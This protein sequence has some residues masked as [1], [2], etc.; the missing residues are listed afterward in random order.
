MKLD[1][2]MCVVLCTVLIPAFLQDPQCRVVSNLSFCTMINYNVSALYVPDPKKLDDEARIMYN[3]YKDSMKIQ[4]K[5]CMTAF[6]SYTCAFRFPKC[7]YCMDENAFCRS[8][9]IDHN[10]A[11]GS[12]PGD[13]SLTCFTGDIYVNDSKICTPQIQ[14][15]TEF[16]CIQPNNL[17]FCNSTFIN[18]TTYA[19]SNPSSADKVWQSMDL[20]TSRRY[21]SFA[22][23]N[24]TANCLDLIKST[25]C[26]IGFSPCDKS[27]GQILDP[28]VVLQPTC[29][30]LRQVCGERV[31][32]KLCEFNH[33]S[34]PDPSKCKPPRNK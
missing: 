7:P 19:V 26:T 28:T 12:G 8:G 23:A 11:C 3:K 27:T 1:V 24:F 2:L 33:P 18:Y 6:K 20:V 21:Q 29:K 25:L 22:S 32:S 16:S 17:K 9:C 14:Q 4:T 13:T 10:V 31:A 5:E 15:E 30:A 34:P